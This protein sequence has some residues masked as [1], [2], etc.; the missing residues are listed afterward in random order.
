MLFQIRQESRQVTDLLLQSW[1]TL[2]NVIDD[3]L[4]LMLQETFES[5][6]Q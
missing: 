1:V 3:L 2:A 4:T 6:D 5:D